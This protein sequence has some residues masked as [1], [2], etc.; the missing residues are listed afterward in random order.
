MATFNYDIDWVLIIDILAKEYGWTIDYIKTLD[1]CQVT[2]L[3]T[4]IKDRYARQNNTSDDGVSAD[5]NSEVS[6]I[7]DFKAMGGKE[8]LNVG[9]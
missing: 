2:K 1:L 6:S 3:L 7:S 9:K 5:N 4:A 8:M